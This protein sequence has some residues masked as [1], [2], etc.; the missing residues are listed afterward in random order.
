MI[1]ARL[2][3]A[4]SLAALTGAT[5]W[6]ARPWS[7]SG[8]WL[9]PQRDAAFTA[10]VLDHLQR[11]LLGQADWRAAPIGWPYPR[12]TA[13]SDWLLG[14][15]LLSLPLRWVVDPLRIYGLACLLG[16]GLTAWAVHHLSA[17]IS[18]RGPH[19]VVAGIGAGLGAVQ[20]SHAHH[21]N[22][23][24]HAALPWAVLALGAGLALDRR[25]LAFAGG[26]LTACAAHFG[27]YMGLHAAFA[28]LV[29]AGALAFERRGAAWTWA[30]AAAGAALGGLSLAP[31]LALYRRAASELDVVIGSDEVASGAWD[32]LDLWG[33][34]S[35]LDLTWSPAPALLVIGLAGAAVAL[36]SAERRPRL[37]AIALAGLGGALLAMG[38]APVL[39]GHAL[40]IPGPHALLSAI[41]GGQLRAPGRW[42]F[43]TELSLALLGAHALMRAT[44]RWPRAGRIATIAAAISLLAGAPPTLAVPRAEA[45]PDPIYAWVAQHPRPGALLELFPE[46]VGAGD[47]PR[48]LGV[49]L[50]HRPIVGGNFARG[51]ELRLAYNRLALRWPDPAADA[52]LRASGVG[53]VLIHPDAR[54]GLR[55]TCEQNGAYRLCP[56]G[57]S[58][59]IPADLDPDGAGPVL[60]LRWDEP[61]QTETVELR[62][63]DGSRQ[64]VQ[65]AALRLAAALTTPET[66][67]LTARLE[68]PCDWPDVAGSSPALLRKAE[69]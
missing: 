16:L 41:S 23:V 6:A 24:H 12:G 15:A 61:P 21:L 54:P 36:R 9:F 29:L 18:G 4:L 32:A 50:H 22:L 19:T 46:R 58:L 11:A 33:P 49:L 68:R 30:A 5:L 17:A 25:G 35:R 27:L 28:A 60:A 66:P 67:G 7:L 42:L 43:L 39:G 20:L 52:L 48:L 2:R 44:G 8:D 1:R 64:T 26:L 45:E 37:I 31:I 34:A 53:L 14:E 56:L 40:G 62:C 3:E 47:T 55:A 57:E 13:M 51:S 65:I 63:E 10:V 59:T 69:R 38:D